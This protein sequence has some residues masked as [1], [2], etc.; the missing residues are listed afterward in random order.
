MA[1][2][3]DGIDFLGIFNAIADDAIR[4]LEGAIFEDSSEGLEPRKHDSC[5]ERKHDAPPHIEEVPDRFAT[6]TATTA[7]LLNRQAGSEALQPPDGDSWSEMEATISDHRVHRVIEVGD[8]GREYIVSNLK[9][10]HMQLSL[11]HKLTK[12]PPAQPLRFRATLLYES[13]EPVISLEDDEL[14]CGTT[15]VTLSRN[16][17]GRFTL[18]MGRNALS[19]SHQ[20]RR[21]C[22]K[23]EPEDPEIASVYPDLTQVSAPMKSV[24]KVLATS[25]APRQRPAPT[26]ALAPVPAPAASHPD[27]S[28]RAL[29]TRDLPMELLREMAQRTEMAAAVS[30]QMARREAL[31][32][33]NQQIQAELAQIRASMQQSSESPGGQPA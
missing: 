21:F 31:E 28:T 33:Q 2:S 16:G 27:T 14:L 9:N 26:P 1:S 6:V 22:V 15:A 23:I 5:A 12:Q 10:F 32:V 11:R 17:I 8:G 30:E 7:S 29:S 13:N 18:R 20:R 24:T 3:D 25:T 4:E 19:Q